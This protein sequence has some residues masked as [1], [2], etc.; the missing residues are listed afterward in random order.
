[1]S[2]EFFTC[3]NS[4]MVKAINPGQRRVRPHMSVEKRQIPHAIS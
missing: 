2:C 4:V 1:L 3:S